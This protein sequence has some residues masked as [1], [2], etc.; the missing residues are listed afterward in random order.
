[1]P[2]P[3]FSHPALYRVSQFFAAVRAGLPVFGQNGRA[4]LTPEEMALVTAIL[5][6]PAQQALF[7]RMSPNDRRLET[8]Q[9]L[10]VEYRAECLIDL[11]PCVNRCPV[12]RLAVVFGPAND[13]ALN[14]ERGP[15]SSVIAWR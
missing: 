12:P 5:P 10:A 9:Q 1:M 7:T 11:L 13:T 15:M 2:G 14:W 6:E 4:G 3:K 8:L